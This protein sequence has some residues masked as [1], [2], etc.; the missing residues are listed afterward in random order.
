MIN[1]FRINY[2]FNLYRGLSCR[3][4]FGH[5]DELGLLQNMTQNMINLKMISKTLNGGLFCNNDTL[6]IHYLFITYLLNVYLQYKGVHYYNFTTVYTQT[7]LVNLKNIYN[8]MTSNTL[9]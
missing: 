5:T 4:I 7:L 9:H 1:T 6:T 3:L 8:E 2:V